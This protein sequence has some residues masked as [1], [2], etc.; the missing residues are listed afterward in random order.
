MERSKISLSQE[1]FEK[2]Q[3]EAKGKNKDVNELVEEVLD[4]YLY[5][6]KVDEVRETLA[7]YAKKSGYKNEEDFFNDMS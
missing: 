3:Q 6:K 5:L 4:N 1:L 2:L 7:P